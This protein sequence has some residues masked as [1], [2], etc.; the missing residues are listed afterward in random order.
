LLDGGLGL[1]DGLRG[2]FL[3]A[4]GSQRDGGQTG[5]DKGQVLFHYRS[6]GLG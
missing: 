4:A 1:R 6:S 3:F 2:F 5:Q